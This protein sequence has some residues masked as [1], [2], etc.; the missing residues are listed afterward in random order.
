MTAFAWLPDGSL[1]ITVEKDFYLPQLDRPRVRGVNVENSDILRFEPASLGEE[2]S[3]T[4]SLYFDG[5]DV[6]LKA[7]REGINALT[8]LVDGR[9]VISTQGPFKAGHLNAKSRD[10]VLFTPTSLG[11]Q[12]AGSWELYF[13]GSSI[14]L[15]SARKDS[16]QAVHVDEVTGSI[17][18]VTK[19]GNGQILVCDFADGDAANCSFELF[20]NGP[21]LGMYC[22]QID[23]IAIR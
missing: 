14:R 6:G 17:Y 18:L 15:L 5:S 7:P 21:V 19:K 2:T 20:W 16:I 22:N 3:G 10:L 13:D 9:I 23:A 11:E 4:W 8:V 1:L 12:T